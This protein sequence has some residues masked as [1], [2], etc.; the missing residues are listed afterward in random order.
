M[1][2]QLETTRSSPASSGGFCGRPP[3]ATITT[4][5]LQ[6]QHVVRLGP[7]IVADVDAQPLKFGQ[8]PVDDADQFLAARVLRGQ[9]DLA[10]GLVGRLQHRDG[11][12]PFGGDPRRLQPR[13]AGADH[14]DLLRRTTGPRNDMRDRR[15]PP[16]RGIVDAE[17]LAA[18][19]DAVEAVG[20]ADA[21][22]DFV[23]AAFHH[24]QHDVRVGDVGA[25]H[26]D[27]VELALG[28]GMAGG[29]DIL[30]ACRMK[31]RE[32]RRRPDLAGEIEMRRRAHAGDRND[33]RSSAASVSIW[34]RMM[35]RKSTLPEAASRR[36]I[37]T[38]SC[39]RQ[40]LV[41][42]LVRDHADADDEICR[43]PLRAPRR[44]PAR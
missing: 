34:P 42:I 27:H 43:R 22:P 31:D 20:G 3:V 9:P 29:G 16:G 41:E 7:D 24:L 37:S 2:S 5:G 26:A 8:P 4:L 30:N 35:L 15:L 1:I 25:R 44:S 11:M 19:I 28:D 14:D 36:A 18:L 39:L 10:A 13:R 21:G 17:R 12:T 6:R 23:L 32:L 33:L 40:A 38:P